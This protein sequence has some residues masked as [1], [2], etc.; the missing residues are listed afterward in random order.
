MLKAGTV[1]TLVV[2]DQEDQGVAYTVGVG[3]I[4]GAPHVSYYL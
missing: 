2:S 1:V 3:M 4:N